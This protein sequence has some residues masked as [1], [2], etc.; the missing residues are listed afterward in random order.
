[1]IHNHK[2]FRSLFCRHLYSV[3][4]LLFLSIIP[5]RGFA[6]TA[7]ITGVKQSANLRAEPRQESA[8]L[9]SIPLG[10][11]V[12]IVDAEH[13]PWLHV[14]Y[15]SKSGYVRDRYLQVENASSSGSS[16]SLTGYL[17]HR[18]EVPWLALLMMALSFLAGRID[19]NWL[20]TLI[21]WGI[22][23]S[24]LLHCTTYE[25]F[26]FISFSDAGF[27]GALIGYVGLIFYLFFSSMLGFL[28]LKN[29]KQDFSDGVMSG[30]LNLLRVVLYILVWYCI[31]DGLAWYNIIIMVFL[32]LYSYGAAHP[33]TQTSASSRRNFTDS[34]LSNHRR[35]RE[36]QQEFDERN[37]RDESERQESLRR[38]YDELMQEANSE[39]YEYERYR[40]KARAERSQAETYE[41]SARG[42][43]N[44]DDES[45]RNRARDLRESAQNCIWKA[46]DYEREA[47]DH[48]RRY[49]EAE[50]EA[51]RLR[52]NIKSL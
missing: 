34:E 40:D 44:S 42:F 43:E 10:E 45:D 30:I 25:P 27:F 12:E 21:G 26:W 39:K 48:R 29:I 11:T 46:E 32:F 19:A 17:S 8:I 1:M 22:P 28:Y 14:R 16:T 18:H 3:I 52:W 7:Q 9:C 47:D 23:L 15:Q 49:E 24:G 13:S 36:R 31:Y 51:E 33:E 6:Q 2:I 37:D 38:K 41:N 4:A 5:A 20:K 35:A 50:K